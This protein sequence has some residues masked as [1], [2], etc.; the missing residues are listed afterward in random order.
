M[1]L[2]H[3][4]GVDKEVIRC[5]NFECTVEVQAR[6]IKF[7]SCHVDRDSISHLEWV[8]WEKMSK[9]WVLKFCTLRGWRGNNE[10]DWDE[11]SS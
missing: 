9:I 10:G 5:T 8:K 3:P 7:G 1:P 4:E 6:D 2:R 11:V